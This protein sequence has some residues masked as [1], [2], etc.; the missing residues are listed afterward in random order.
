MIYLELLRAIFHYQTMTP[1]ISA[2][3]VEQNGRKRTVASQ[4]VRG[5]VMRETHGRAFSVHL[6]GQRVDKVLSRTWGWK[7]MYSDATSHAKNCPKCAFAT[8]EARPGHPPYNSIPV[9]RPFQI[10]GTDVMDLPRT[11]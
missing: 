11:E 8:G 7:G 10:I 5:K 6:S 4:H 3:S 9:Q 2:V 1:Q